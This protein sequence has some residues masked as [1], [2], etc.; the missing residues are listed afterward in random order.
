[1]DSGWKLTP[2]SMARLDGVSLPTAVVFAKVLRCAR[3]DGR[4]VLLKELAETLHLEPQPPPVQRREVFQRRAFTGA[5]G[6][7]VVV[8]D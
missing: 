4:N 7:D 1:M 5:S 3:G 8:A 2:R 6:V